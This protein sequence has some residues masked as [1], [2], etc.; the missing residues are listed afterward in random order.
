MTNLKV[1]KEGIDK[2]KVLTREQMW[3]KAN[4]LFPTDYEKDELRSQRAGY[5]IYSSTANDK[6]WISDCGNH[7][8]LN[9]ENE[10][11]NIW[12]EEVS[13][14]AVKDALEI[15]DDALYGIEDKIDLKLRDLIPEIEDARI[16]LSEVFSILN[17]IR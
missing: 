17:S 2:M 13:N 16:K 10:T 4:E 5:D 7:L 12:I 15:I 1:K 9:L 6:M 3:D 14:W 11:I 8:E